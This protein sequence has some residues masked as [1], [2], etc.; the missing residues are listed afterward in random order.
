[1][2]NR[3]IHFAQRPS[4]QPSL[5][6]FKLVENELGEE[7]K[8][9]QVLVKNLWMSVDP[10]MRPRMNDVKSYIPPFQLDHV[11]EGGAIGVV[12]KSNNP[13][14][15]VGTHVESM[16]GWRE[17]FVSSGKGLGIRDTS[18]IAPQDYLGILGMPGITAYV[19]TKILGEAKAGDT[20]YVSGAG[21]A[22]GSLVCQ[23]AKALGCTVV[24]SAGSDAKVEWLLNTAKIDAAF[25]YKTEADFAAKLAALCPKGI[26]LFFD[27]VGG[28]QLDGALLSM[29]KNG[30]AILCGTIED[31]NE[32]PEKRHGV[33]N[34]FKVV[35]LGVTMKGFVVLDYMA[36][37]HQAF[38]ADMAK[39]R[40][41]GKIDWQETVYEGV[42]K[43]PEAFLGLF[44]G[45][46]LGKMLVKL[47]D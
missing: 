3:E 26:D 34:L 40:S 43:A 11:L 33:K 12:E 2:I 5:D 28:S 19:G 1:M 29:R 32:A 45:A 10:Y 24:G 15:P 30:R 22:V 47:A 20:V 9:G 42:D 27:N 35:A 39:W 13:K 7:L 31:Y 36:E 44:N 16:N 23:I 37:H 46:N 14:L 41:E 25:N 6:C 21:G 38:T 4:P 8:D 18:T 17:Y